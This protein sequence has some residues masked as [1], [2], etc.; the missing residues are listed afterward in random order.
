MDTLIDLLSKF[1]TGQGDLAVRA[2]IEQLDIL[3]Y[4]ARWQGAS[5]VTLSA[6]QGAKV[7]LD[8]SELQPR[9]M[10]ALSSPYDRRRAVGVKH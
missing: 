10:R 9:R 6:I 5:A 4:D 1:P 2:M 3:E 8:V 7:L